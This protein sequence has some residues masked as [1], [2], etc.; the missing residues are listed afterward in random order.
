[1]K[2]L[3]FVCLW[4]VL[5]PCL[6]FAHDFEVDGIYYNITSEE[7]MTCE[8]TF[9]SDKKFVDNGYKYYK[10]V[11]FVSENVKFDGK[12]YTVTAIG[13][14]AFSMNDE[15]LS[16]VMPNTI[17]SI[18]RSAFNA[19][20]KLK[21]LTIPCSV[22]NIGDF[23]FMDLPSL[24]H[25]AVDEYNIAFDSRGDCNAI[26]RT[27]TNTL[28]VGCKTTVIPDG[29]EVIARYAFS[30]CMTNFARLEPLEINIP[31]SVEVIEPFAFQNCGS[32]VAVNFSEGLKRIGRWV[33][34]GTA[35]ERLEIPASVIDIDDEAFIACDSLKVIKVKKGNKV[36]DSRKG[37]NAIIESATGRLLLGCEGTT[38]PDGVKVISRGAFARSGIKKVK[39]P[40]SLEAIE[41]GAFAS[42]KELKKLVIPGSVKNIQIEIL[43]GSGIEELIVEDGVEKIPYYAFF[44]CHKLRYVSLPAS[45]KEFGSNGAVFVDCPELVR[46]DV[47]KKNEHYYSNGQVIVDKSTKTIVDGW[48][49]EVCNAA[50]FPEELLPT[51]IGENA[52]RGHSLLRL[53]VL[54]AT[55][56]KI[57]AGA[58]SNCKNLRQ[59]NC[60]AA[61][62]PELGK[63]AFKIDAINGKEPTPLQEQLILLVPKASIE[64]YKSAPGWKE[65]KKTIDIR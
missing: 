63:D 13:E 11:V 39:L 60:H 64:A 38:V 46:V 25:L 6:A 5:L 41:R 58:F 50:D 55:I 22:R 3:I 7:K 54:P 23:A 28:L 45:L 31:G 49:T 2:K 43:C 15:L 59:L 19:C 10:D 61:V 14:H 48:G 44:E 27:K 33:F 26:I 17:V 65:F 30:S 4:A 36:Y 29:V 32:L 53:V 40:S 8:V 21:S 42:C 47:D 1:M 51:G 12:E 18:G 16:V 52:F 57:G 24:E 56:E 35:I 34:L 62:A 20:G 9:P 37:C